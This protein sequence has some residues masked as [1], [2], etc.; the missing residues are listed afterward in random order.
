MVYG[1]PIC[2]ISTVIVGG[3]AITAR[4]NRSLAEGRSGRPLARHKGGA[5]RPTLFALFSPTIGALARLR[6]TATRL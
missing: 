1:G 5:R 2:P 3:I 6:I 4:R